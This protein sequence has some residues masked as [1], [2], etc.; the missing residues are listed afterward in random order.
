MAI[1]RLI[2]TSVC[3]SVLRGRSVQLSSRFE[4]YGFEELGISSITE[5]ELRVGAEKGGQGSYAHKLIDE[6]FLP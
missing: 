6:F 3:I 2:D 1:L 5:A 4:S